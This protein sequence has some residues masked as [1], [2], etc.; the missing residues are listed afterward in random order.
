M[1]F[2]SLSGLLD[3]LLP[4]QNSRPTFCA[5]LTKNQYCIRLPHI[6][7]MLLLGFWDLIHISSNFSFFVGSYSAQ[8][9]PVTLNITNA[10]QLAG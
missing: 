8:K 6:P 3:Y 10:G 1:C 5:C 2:I 9:S 4:I 7:G